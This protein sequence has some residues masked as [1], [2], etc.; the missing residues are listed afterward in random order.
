MRTAIGVV[1]FNSS[2]AVGIVIVDDKMEFDGERAFIKNVVGQDEKTDIIN[3]ADWGARFPIKEA[4]SLVKNHG[5]EI[6]V[7]L[8]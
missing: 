2:T 3:V 7:E 6:N 1:W 4:I 8:E 5:K